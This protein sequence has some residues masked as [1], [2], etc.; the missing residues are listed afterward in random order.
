V[1][2]TGEL[3]FLSAAVV[4]I[5]GAGSALVGIGPGIALPIFDGGRG[6]AEFELREHQYDAA[7]AEYQKT[8]IAAFGDVE[9]ALLGYQAAVEAKARWSSADALIAAQI[10][11]LQLSLAAGHASRLQLIALQQQAIEIQLSSLL[12]QRQ[13]LDSMVL[14]YQAL[15]GASPAVGDEA[16]AKAATDTSTDTGSGESSTR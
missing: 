12:A 8:V 5:L 3:G 9:K 10:Q 4:H 13:H 1:Q 6:A 11:R 15:G 2:L 16:T 14:L 7:L